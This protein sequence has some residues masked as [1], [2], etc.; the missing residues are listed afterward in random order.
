M[1]WLTR[2]PVLRPQVSRQQLLT[3]LLYNLGA[4][5]SLS[6]CKG[7]M[8]GALVPQASSSPSR[9]CMMNRHVPLLSERG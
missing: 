8:A 1:V 5:S 2:S 6:P 7:P 9:T 4:S 3:S